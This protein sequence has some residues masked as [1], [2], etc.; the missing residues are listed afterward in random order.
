MSK[1]YIS[2]N[3]VKLSAEFRNLE[4]ML[5]DAE[6]PK[7]IIYNYK[8]E[9]LEEITLTDAN[10]E[11]T[12][13]YAYYYPTPLKPTRIIYEFKGE[14]SGMVALDRGEFTTRFVDK[15]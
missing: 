10:K 8:W 6:F 3:T 11:G 5:I 4:N 13:K 15:R 14:M 7:L 2:G 9:K 12:G 1:L